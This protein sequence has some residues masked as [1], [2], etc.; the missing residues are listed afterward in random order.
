MVGDWKS[1]NAAYSMMA[2]TNSTA[3]RHKIYI[4]S[5][6][7]EKGMIFIVCN[8]PQKPKQTGRFMSHVDKTP[9][10]T[11]SRC[12]VLFCLQKVSI[13]INSQRVQNFTCFDAVVFFWDWFSLFLHVSVHKHSAPK[14]TTSWIYKAALIDTRIQSQSQWNETNGDR[15]QFHMRFNM[16]TLCQNTRGKTS[17]IDSFLVSFLFV[18]SKYEWRTE[19]N[20]WKRLLRGGIR[21]FY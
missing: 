1:E 8:R 3:D 17:W 19:T 16:Q 9:R 14:Q 6:H 2:A 21:K 13:W 15:V 11:V 12:S 10:R 18:V 4:R 5:D 20:E 7:I